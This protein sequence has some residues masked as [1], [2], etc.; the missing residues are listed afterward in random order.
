MNAQRRTARS[1]DVIATED[2]VGD[3]HIRFFATG[4]VILQ[5]VFVSDSSNEI[6]LNCVLDDGV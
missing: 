1:I 6:D 4:L 3:R 5:R 2:S